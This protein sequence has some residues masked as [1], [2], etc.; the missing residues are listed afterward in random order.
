MFQILLP[1]RK[2]KEKKNREGKHASKLLFLHNQATEQTEKK[3][4]EKQCFTEYGCLDC[5][6][7]MMWRI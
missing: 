1:T 4:E 3:E 5:M 2:T 7:I 6:H